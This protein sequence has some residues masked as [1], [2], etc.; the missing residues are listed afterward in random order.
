[1]KI[2]SLFIGALLIAALL[3]WLFSVQVERAAQEPEEP[4]V[5]GERPRIPPAAARSVSGRG[6]GRSPVEPPATGPAEPSPVPMVAAPAEPLGWDPARQDPLA[7]EVAVEV[8]LRPPKSEGGIADP[9]AVLAYAPDA[10][11]GDRPWFSSR[12]AEKGNPPEAEPAERPAAP[13][14][15]PEPRNTAEWL[16][17]AREDL[18]NGESEK[19]MEAFR[20]ALRAS[21]FDYDVLER[22]ISD[23]CTAGLYDDALALR[24]FYAEQ[25]RLSASRFHFLTG[26]VLFQQNRLEEAE[27]ELR[28]AVQENPMH[29]QAHFLLG[30][31]EQR[32]E[33]PAAAEIHFR[34]AV[35]A[36]AE[37]DEAR[38]QLGRSLAQQG[39]Y[40]EARREFETLVS[41][42]PNDIRA[43]AGLAG[44]LFAEGR[45]EDA[46]QVYRRMNEIRPG[47]AEVINQ[48]AVSLKRLGK[49]L[50]ALQAIDAG[51]E[52][53]PDSFVL[54]FNKACA[55]ATMGRKGEALE[56]LRL[57]RDS[58]PE[59]LA[60]NID[61]VDF[62]SLRDR[63]EYQDIREQL[64][65]VYGASAPG[66]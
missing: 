47:S 24:D 8:P 29:A 45:Y 5:P 40:Q 15:A 34:N 38:Y 66:S 17:S 21:D 43:L 7:I 64:L 18:Q 28:A 65:S 36:S 10:E 3:G 50:E 16:Q 44:T 27:R 51:L 1:M 19:A 35:F 26:T 4:L 23:F 30:R 49:D 39:R 54:Q 62:A 14:A 13:Q 32:Q 53:Q 46:L 31:I 60:R 25:A 20:S 61:D 42:Y 9:S 22:G 63:P 58:Y 37:N 2:F 52:V 6:E 48:I 41:M 33:D 59:Q 56:I 11:E 12:P 55:L 57:L